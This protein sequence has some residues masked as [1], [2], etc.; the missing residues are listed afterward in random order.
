MLLNNPVQRNSHKKTLWSYRTAFK[1][2]FP[3][4]NIPPI[5]GTHSQRTFQRNEP[6]YLPT[7]RSNELPRDTIDLL[8]DNELLNNELSM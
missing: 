7:L 8:P 6:S 1:V 2:N 5:K 3:I 4:Y